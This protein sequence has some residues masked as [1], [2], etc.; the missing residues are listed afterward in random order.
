MTFCK[1]RMAIDVLRGRFPG[2]LAMLKAE[3]TS[4]SVHHKGQENWCTLHFYFGDD[5]KAC[6]DAYRAMERLYEIDRKAGS[7]EAPTL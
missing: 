2:A 7:Q 3:D 1:L 4:I 6:G 5:A